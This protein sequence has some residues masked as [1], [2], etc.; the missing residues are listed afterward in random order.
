MYD[1]NIGHYNNNNNNNGQSNYLCLDIF[2][3]EK[4]S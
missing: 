3:E 4:L 2:A 1:C